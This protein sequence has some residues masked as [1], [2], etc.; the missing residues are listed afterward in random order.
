MTTCKSC[1]FDQQHICARVFC[2]FTVVYCC[3]T[4]TNDDDDDDDDDVKHQVDQVKK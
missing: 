1:Y 2:R 3:E 4:K